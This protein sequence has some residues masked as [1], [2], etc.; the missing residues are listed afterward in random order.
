M[1]N[2]KRIVS[3]LMV[4]SVAMLGAAC[5]DGGEDTGTTGTDTVEQDDGT[6]TGD[7]GLTETETET[8]ADS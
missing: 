3:A 5:A 7:T 6:T 8:P 2:W 1:K 4:G